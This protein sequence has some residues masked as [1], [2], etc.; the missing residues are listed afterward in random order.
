LLQ[1]GILFECRRHGSFYRSYAPSL[2]ISICFPHYYNG[3]KSVATISTEPRLYYCIS[4]SLKF[5]AMASPPN[6]AIKQLRQFRKYQNINCCYHMIQVLLSSEAIQFLFYF[7][8]LVQDSCFLHAR[9]RSLPF[10]F[11]VQV[12]YIHHRCWPV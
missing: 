12:Q 11:H 4:K 2:R 10:Q 6:T 1:N 5:T 9:F 7:L 8:H 3:L